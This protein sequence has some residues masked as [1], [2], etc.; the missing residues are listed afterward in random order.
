MINYKVKTLSED[1]NPLTYERPYMSNLRMLI[2]TLGETYYIAKNVT[3]HAVGFTERLVFGEK[4]LHQRLKEY[5]GQKKIAFLYHGYL[6]ARAG[7]ERME[8]FLESDLFNIFAISGGYQPYSQDIR[9]SAEHE[10]H[11]LEYVL[12]QVEAEEVFLIGHSQ[13]G[14]V[15]RY[16]LQKMGLARKH[17][18]I[19]Q[20]ITLH[21]P[22]MGSYIASVGFAHK[23]AT[24]ALGRVVPGFPTIRGESAM[25]MIP[26]SS[27]LRDLNSQPLPPN[28]G[29]TSIYSYID[30]LVWP[31]RFARMP[32]PEATNILL[33]KIGHVS[34]LYNIQVFE[35]ILKTMLL[36]P[37]GQRTEDSTIID[38]DVLMKKRL[39]RMG[40]K[41][42]EIVRSSD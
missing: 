28:V 42:E 21:T 13:G 6:Q 11:I 38:R 26:G 23:A 18:E 9:L 31:A 37:K 7:Y 39:Q 20:A 36:T 34:P 1:V 16:M 5:R 19:S 41:F 30:P 29:W 12:S 14:L 15:I 22:N 33:K 8:H 4:Y 24:S 40:R 17:P 2:S 3:D 25:Q 32:Y 10:A 35:L 27:F